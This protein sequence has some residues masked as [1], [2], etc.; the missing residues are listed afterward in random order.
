MS[1]ACITQAVQMVSAIKNSKVLSQPAGENTWRSAY[2]MR[3]T[4]PIATSMAITRCISAGAARTGRT[5]RAIASSAMP[6][7]GKISRCN[8]S[9]PKRMAGLMFSAAWRTRLPGGAVRTVR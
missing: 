2:T 8:P 1:I 9:R 6:V 3:R 5:P 7:S 4:T